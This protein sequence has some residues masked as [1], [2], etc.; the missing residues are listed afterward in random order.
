LTLRACRLVV[1]CILVGTAATFVQGGRP[2]R[3]DGGGESAA[4]KAA[5]KADDATVAPYARF[6]LGVSGAVDFAA[7]PAANDVCKLTP[8]LTP[9]N[10]E[11][12]YCTNASGSDLPSA[13]QNAHLSAPGSAGRVDQGVRVGD[14]RVMLALDYAALANLLLGVRLGYVLNGYSGAAAVRDGRALDP[15]VHAELRVTYVF[16]RDPLSHEGFAPTAFVGGGISEFDVHTS[17]LVTF[18]NVAGAQSA[19][20]WLTDAPYFLTLGGGARYQFSPRLQLT[21]G[22]RLNAAFNENG[23]LATFGP[24]VTVQAGF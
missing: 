23:I 24:E 16:G 3:A 17:T 10:S 13:A 21:L 2:A 11:H 12:Y 20:V 18:D 14:V 8:A 5:A 7:M 4:R 9:D 15:K 1:T 22:A 19:G 6:W